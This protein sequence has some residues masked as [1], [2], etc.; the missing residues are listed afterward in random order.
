MKIILNF[1]C[2]AFCFQSFAQTFTKIT[3]GEIVNT[4]SASRS[5]NFVDVNGDGWDDIFI[6][7]G[8]SFGQ[9]NMLYLN[10][11]DGTFTKISNDPIV[12]DGSGSDGATFADAD[13]DGDLDACVVTW[14]NQVN[15]FYRNQGNGQFVHEA[16]N[17]IGL[18]GTYSESASWGDMD[19][20][21][22][23]DL[24]ITNSAGIK[25][26]KLFK[27]DGTGDFIAITSG[28][29]V[30]DEDLSRSVDWIDYDNDGDQDLFVTNETN[31][32][33]NLYQNDGDGNFTK[34]TSGVIVE[35]LKN[36]AGSSWGDIDNDGDFDLF[37]AN[38]ENQSNQLFLN[39]G[40]GN[41]TTVSQ[42]AIVSDGGCS[43]GSAYADADN[44]GDLDLFVC[45][46]FCNGENNFFYINQGDGTF[47]KETTTLPATDQGWTFGCAW[48][49]YN[50]DGFMDLVLANCKDE[51]Q[52]NALYQNNGNDN[53]WFK[54]NCEGVTC[55]RS[56]IG[57]IIKIKATIDGN[58]VWQ[59]R[60]IAGQSGYCSQNS[61]NVHFGLGDANLIDSL[62]IQW[63]SGLEQVFENVEADKFCS[64]KE[65][66][67]IDCTVTSIVDQKKIITGELTIFPN[68]VSE[69]L[70][71]IENPFFES[72][73]EVVL[74]LYAQNGQLLKT[75][76]IEN[77]ELTILLNTHNLQKGAYQLVLETDGLSYS[78]TLIIP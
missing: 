49:D 45:N 17:V 66:G 76:K 1:I 18:G 29:H 27:N 42:G 13:N 15:Y 52:S 19:N 32:K 37:V 12:Q 20:D 16:N 78:E 39:N 54:L 22:W 67:S 38:W 50:N 10:N 56:A 3:S 7:N 4:P 64:I 62:I 23:V 35:F 21:G 58:A 44:D 69:E 53:H 46:A 24:Y 51:N 70:V 59:M 14:H 68:P 75:Q 63:P 77:Q 5:A 2:L 48:G 73:K 72:Q 61:L 36:S 26:N 25:N 74:K 9:N 71:T 31:S 60:R 33:N 11:H 43:F 6:S 47:V 34:I 65:G 55:N 40:D 30:N 28:S 8:P 57:A 41:F